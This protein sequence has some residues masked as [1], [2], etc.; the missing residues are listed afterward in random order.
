MA[1]TITTTLRRRRPLLLVIRLNLV[2]HFAVAIGVVSGVSH[3]PSAHILLLQLLPMNTEERR[4][5]LLLQLLI[6]QDSEKVAQ[7]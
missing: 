1:F 6:I 2:S 7:D 3:S 5:L 4:L